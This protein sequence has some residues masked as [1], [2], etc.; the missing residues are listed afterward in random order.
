M[1]PDRIRLSG[2]SQGIRPTLLPGSGVF[3]PLKRQR[4][5]LLMPLERML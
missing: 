2:I 5:A 4:K 1:L 3:A